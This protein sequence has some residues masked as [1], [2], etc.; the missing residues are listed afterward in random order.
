MHILNRCVFSGTEEV[1]EETGEEMRSFSVGMENNPSLTNRKGNG[2]EVKEEEKKQQD[3]NS[4]TDCE[5]RLK[6]FRRTIRQELL[7]Y[8]AVPLY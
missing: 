3:G 1:C 5:F 7:K 8:T 2:Q 6:L 4:S